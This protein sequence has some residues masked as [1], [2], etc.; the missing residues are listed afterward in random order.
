MGEGI[1]DKAAIQRGGEL[2]KSFT[3]MY[4]YFSVLF[5]QLTEKAPKGSNAW[6]K[7]AVFAAKWF[8]LITLPVVLDSLIG[9]GMRDV[10]SDDPEDLAKH[11]ASE[12]GKFAA[13]TVP[14]LSMIVDVASGNEPRYA[15]WMT[16]VLRGV[17]T[18]AQGK[19]PTERQRR[20]AVDALGIMLQQP[21]GAARN[22]YRYLEEYDNMEEPVRNLLFRS[23]GDWK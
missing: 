13:R 19:E 10:K 4:S 3:T 11:L 15:P 22:A 23:P 16:T 18:A 7:T 2:T 14:G 6:Q 21:T 5:N 1:K 8:W 17:K 20:E 9:R 12:Q